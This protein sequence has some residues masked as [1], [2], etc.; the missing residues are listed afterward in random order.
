MTSIT[1]GDLMLDNEKCKEFFEGIKMKIYLLDSKMSWETFKKIQDKLVK[2]SGPIPVNADRSIYE[3]MKERKLYCWFTEKG[4][5]ML[6]SPKK[7]EGE[8]YIIS[9]PEK[10]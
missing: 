9:S 4:I 7:P 5:D 6:M 8:I 10:L 1:V 3:L 2:L